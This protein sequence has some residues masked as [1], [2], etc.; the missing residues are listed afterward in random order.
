M[1]E[2]Q[3]T[4]EVPETQETSE[5]PKAE[6]RSNKGLEIGRMKATITRQAKQKLKSENPSWTKEQL[7]SHF[8]TKVRSTLNYT[9]NEKASKEDMEKALPK[10]RKKKAPQV[11]EEQKTETLK[12][13]P[14]RV[15]PPRVQPPKV[16]PA[17]KKAPPKEKVVKVKEAPKEIQ[18]PKITFDSQ[19]CY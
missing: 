3:N 5:A 16:E 2:E 10:L 9:G 19:N 17:P 18:K 14:P 13:E 7:D 4:Q 15:E 6:K 12:V 8:E 1:T 11:V